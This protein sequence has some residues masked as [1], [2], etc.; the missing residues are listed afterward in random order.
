MRPGMEQNFGA[1]IHM[2]RRYLISQIKQL[3]LG[4]DSIG[5]KDDD[6]AYYYLLDEQLLQVYHT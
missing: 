2:T 1:E 4:E 3:D 5:L 6:W